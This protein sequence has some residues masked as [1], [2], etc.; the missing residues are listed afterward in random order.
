MTDAVPDA[1]VEAYLDEAQRIWENTPIL[2]KGDPSLVRAGL[3][4]ALPH[5]A[6]YQA[7]RELAQAVALAAASSRERLPEG[8][9]EVY[10]R[11]NSPIKQALERKS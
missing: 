4:A 5:M 11:L 2:K 8:V 1:A 9:F 3:R 7:L 6:E 10:I